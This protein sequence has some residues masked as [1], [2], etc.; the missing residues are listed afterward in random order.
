[1]EMDFYERDLACYKHLSYD[2]VV[3]GGCSVRTKSL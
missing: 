2:K 3:K 1:M